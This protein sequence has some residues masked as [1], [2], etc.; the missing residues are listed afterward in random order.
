M[1][2]LSILFLNKT[3]CLPIIPN[4]NILVWL[5]F[6]VKNFILCS[7][8]IPVG[9]TL[10]VALVDKNLNYMGRHKTCPYIYI[11]THKPVDYIEII[12]YKKTFDKAVFLFKLQLV[13]I[14]L[15]FN[16]KIQPLK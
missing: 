7:K 11:A 4:L 14:F 16:L 1:P 2:N 15:K 9:A 6:V 5:C 3:L 10:V 8:K 13:S 12:L